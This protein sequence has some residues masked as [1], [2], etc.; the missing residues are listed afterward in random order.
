M[1]MKKHKRLLCLLTALCM[2]IGHAPVVHAE[3]TEDEDKD[4]TRSPYFYGE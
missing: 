2:L 4:Q 3:E 1:K